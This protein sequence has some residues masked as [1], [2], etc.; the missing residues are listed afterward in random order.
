MSTA[1][2]N[3]ARRMDQIYRRQRL[4]YDLTR[5][6]YLA[7]RDELI[8]RLSPPAGGSVLEIGCGTGRNLIEAAR[9]YPDARFHGIDVS[10]QMLDTAAA[11]IARAKL[12]PRIDIARAD[13]TNFDA[14][15]LFGCRVFD[16]VFISYALSMIPCWQQV[17]D[18]SVTCLREG[19]ALHVVDFGQQER[20]PRFCKSALF[21]WLACFDVTPRKELR[22]ELELLAA[23]Q[24]LTLEFSARH[25]GYAWYAILTR[26]A[27][28]DGDTDPKSR[29]G[30]GRPGSP[31]VILTAHLRG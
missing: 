22:Q 17:L 20:L 16:R 28:M 11:A 13:A 31:H 25:R 23:R 18:L 24:K 2:N 30:P 5:K 29:M 15:L 26:P 9:C 27:W 10:A 3:A 21:E 4:I 8:R 7:G 12:S 14:H 6:Y 1:G 19:G